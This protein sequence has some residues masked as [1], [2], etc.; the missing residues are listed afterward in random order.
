MPAA[1]EQFS[2]WAPRCG[3][4]PRPQSAR[5]VARP[6][7]G[8]AHRPP[9]SSIVVRCCCIY[10]LKIIRAVRTVSHGRDGKHGSGR[11]DSCSDSG[12]FRRRSFDDCP[13]RSVCVTGE[14]LTSMSNFCTKARSQRS[15]ARAHCC[16]TIKMP[17]RH[18]ALPALLSS[19]G[20]VQ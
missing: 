4:V 17:Q 7:M 13:D 1:D 5:A 19:R 10:D 14:H 18:V 15:A 9:S 2:P 8:W 3:R 12:R 20:C 16:R 11:A 6:E